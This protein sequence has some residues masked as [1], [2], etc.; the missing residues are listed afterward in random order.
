M[1]A[2]GN[3]HRQGTWASSYRSGQVSF[4]AAVIFLL[5]VIPLSGFADPSQNGIQAVASS[6]SVGPMS[7]ALEGIVSQGIS[8]VFLGVFA[9]VAVPWL[10]AGLALA[11][12][13]LRYR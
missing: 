5:L 12:S 13:H 8:W 4:G 1:R 7:Q 9:L 2:K 3:G 11:A 10:I 6:S